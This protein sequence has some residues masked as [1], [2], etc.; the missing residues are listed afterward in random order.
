MQ[1]AA[2]GDN[3]N[4]SN[5]LWGAAYGVIFVLAMEPRLLEVFVNRLLSPGLG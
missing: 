3:I 4:H 1:D 5:H 2:G